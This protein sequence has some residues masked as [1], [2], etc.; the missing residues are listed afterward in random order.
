MRFL[1]T[2]SFLN[3]NDDVAERERVKGNPFFIGRFSFNISANG[4]HTM[5]SLLTQRSS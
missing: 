4:K 2:G 5:L 1:K 3:K